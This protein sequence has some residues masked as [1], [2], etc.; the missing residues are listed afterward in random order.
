MKYFDY[1]VLE[2]F[3]DLNVVINGSQHQIISYMQG[4]HKVFP[5]LQTF[6]TRKLSGIQKEHML[7]WTNVL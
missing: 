5:W 3:C 1:F 6:I 4:E 2:K 7:K